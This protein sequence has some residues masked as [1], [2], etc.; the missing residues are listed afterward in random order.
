MSA[1]AIFEVRGLRKRFGDKVVLDGIDLTLRRGE[2]LALLGPSGCGKSIL[3][4]CLVGLVPFDEG[5]VLFDGVSV[6]AMT[7]AELTALRRRVGLMFQYNALFDSMT[8]AENTSYGLR[9]HFAETMTE[10]EIDARVDE[11]LTAVGL[12]GT[13]LL[14]PA[15]MSGG[16]RKRVG[17]ARTMALRPEVILYD[18]PTMGLDPVNAH[19]IDAIIV[20]LHKRFGIAA[21]MVTHDMELAFS[22]ADRVAMILDGRIVGCDTPERMREH[23]DPRVSDFITGIDHSVLPVA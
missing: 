5:E 7:S 17:I 13:Q 9:E 3:L 11:V 10:A 15:E 6:A 1:D 19:R 14:K 22:A 12:P 16:M 4:K 23:P 18:E 21:V 2:T 8:V 20:D